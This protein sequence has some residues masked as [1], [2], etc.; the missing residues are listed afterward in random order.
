[1]VDV[2]KRRIV[3]VSDDSPQGGQV[4]IDMENVTP[5]R[6]STGLNDTTSVTSGQAI[7]LTVVLADGMDPKTV[8]W[9]KDNNAIAGATGLTYTKANS[10]AADSGTYK[11]VAHDGYG[12]IISDSTVVTVS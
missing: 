5:L 11:V 12:N 7:T 9:Y 10:A 4:E 3:G 8:Q 2:I 1:M 6:F